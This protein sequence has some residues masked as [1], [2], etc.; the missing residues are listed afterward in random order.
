VICCLFSPAGSVFSKDLGTFGNTYPIKERDALEEVKAAAAKVNWK[1][2][3][4]KIKPQN[5]RPTYEVQLPRAEANRKFL[6]DMTYTLEAD[7]PDGKGGIVYPKGYSFNPLDYV[8]F[9]RTVVVIN[10]DDSEQVS[11]LKRSPYVKQYDALL[12][13]TEGRAVALS[14]QL[15]RPV[16]YMDNKAAE[17]FRLQAVPSVIRQEGR[18]MQVEEVLVPRG[19]R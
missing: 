1:K 4:A 8:P 15:K 17:R 9:T 12:F 7:I 3:V 16:S 10:G 18:M 19:K 6:V 2:E 13:L 11:W 5:Y 14:N